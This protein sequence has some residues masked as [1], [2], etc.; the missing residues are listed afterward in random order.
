[1]LNQLLTNQNKLA[2]ASKDSAVSD[3]A[4]LAGFFLGVNMKQI[5]L[6]QG[7][8]ALVDDED[9]EW[10][11]QWKWCASKGHSTFYAHR[12]Y[13]KNK[14]Y[15]LVQM[16]RAILG[17]LD[18]KTKLTDHINH[19]GLDNRRCNIRICTK[20]QNQCNIRPYK[21][22]SSKYK[23]VSFHKNSKRWIAYIKYNHNYEY[24]GYYKEE[25][26][27]A[28]AYDSRARELFGEFAYLNF[29]KG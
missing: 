5:Q 25:K 19:N 23:G 21:N 28:K 17:I 15:H 4:T 27:A 20:S 2:R 8:V 18:E 1:M 9:Y 10:L 13:Y 7:Q 29:R 12:K 16:H 14:K 22:T 26:D 24:L 11:K 6:T 3:L